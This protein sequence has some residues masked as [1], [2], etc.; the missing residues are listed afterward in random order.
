MAL[1]WLAAP[2]VARSQ[3]EARR[4]FLQEQLRHERRTLRAVEAEVGHPHHEAVW[5]LQLIIR[6]FE[7]ELA[8]LRQ[9]KADLARRAPA[10]N[11]PGHKP[12]SG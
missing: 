3:V 11:P 12:Q 1:S 6:Q 7:T 2:S 4:A 5:M 10:R 8:W 9:V